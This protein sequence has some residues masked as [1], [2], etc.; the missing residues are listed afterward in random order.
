MVYLPTFT[1]KINHI[2]ANILYMDPMGM[3]KWPLGFFFKE[4]CLA[5]WEKKDYH[6]GENLGTPA[7]RIIRGLVRGK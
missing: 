5:G 7:W 4:R 2:R 3:T 1:I 6:Q